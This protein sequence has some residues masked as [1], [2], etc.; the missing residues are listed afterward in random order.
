MGGTGLS[1]RRGAAR[2]G[3][4]VAV[5]VCTGAVRADEP[6]KQVKAALRVCG[7]PNNLPFSNSKEEGFEN[8]IAAL[9]ARDLGLNLEYTW[10]PQRIG[11]IR[12]TLKKKTDPTSDAF[13]CDLVIGVPAGYGLAATTKPYYRST[14][15]MVFVRGHGLDAVRTPDD[16]MKLDPAAL[17][18]LRFGVFDRTPP[19]A[20][21]LQHGLMQ[22]A[23]PYQIQTGDPD[24]YP[25]EV[26]EKDLAAGQI[27][28]ALVWGPI[29]GY[30][31]TR[32][33]AVPMAV[34]AFPPDAGIRFDFAVSMGVR[35]G[36]GAWKDRV[37]HFLDE[38][39]AAIHAILDDYG[40]PQLELNA[41]R[42]R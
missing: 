39:G 28:V 11:F 14:Y 27:D 17:R 12:N 26:V 1:A 41:A 20:W 32:R 10:F 33:A 35:T 15:A 23:I 24:R 29:A 4:A 38:N 3:L 6:A 36:E 18:A 30:F 8:K 40:V 5:L 21:L 16:L 34:V 22:Q 37:D 7:D 2:A 25:G 9:L 31:A 42:A 13:T 19:T